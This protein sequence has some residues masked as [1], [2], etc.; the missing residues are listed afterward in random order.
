MTVRRLLR[1][2]L[3]V[4]L[5]AGVSMIWFAA[6]VTAATF[7]VANFE[8]YASTLVV[9]NPTSAAIELPDFWKS[10]GVGGAPL[11]L[12]PFSTFRYEGWPRAGYGGVASIEVPAPLHAYVELRDPNTKLSRFF[13]LGAP[14]ESAQVMDLLTTG[15][16]AFVFIHAAEKATITVRTFAGA[17]QL[18]EEYFVVGADE[19]IIP[20]VPTGATR[21]TVTPGMPLCGQCPTSPVHIFGFLSARPGGEMLQVDALPIITLSTP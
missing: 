13:D 2:L 19:T 20:S 6:T 15:W 12:E 14:V 5:F 8:A 10:L 11:R 18:G 1:L 3:F 16:A 4:L 9:N 7:P 21:V 17:E